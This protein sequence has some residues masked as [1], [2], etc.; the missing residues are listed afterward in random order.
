MIFSFNKKVSQNFVLYNYV[1][2]SQSV[3][4]YKIIKRQEIKH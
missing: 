4:K 3:Y 2:V 1:S